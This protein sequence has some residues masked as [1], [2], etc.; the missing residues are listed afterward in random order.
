[1]RNNYIIILKGLYQSL[2]NCVHLYEKICDIYY[3]YKF[4]FDKNNFNIT[5][6]SYL[7]KLDI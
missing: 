4:Y 2:L 3:N 6:F 5:Y 1:M 7:Y